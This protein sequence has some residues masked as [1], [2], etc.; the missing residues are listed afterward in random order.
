[1][2]LIKSLKDNAITKS[3]SGMFMKKLFAYIELSD[4][5]E[6]LEKNK[7]EKNK[8]EKN[9]YGAIYKLLKNIYNTTQH[10]FTLKD[11]YELNITGL[12]V[13]MFNLDTSIVMSFIL[14]A[15]GRK[16]IFSSNQINVPNSLVDL[17]MHVI[18][19]RATNEF[20]GFTTVMSMSKLFNSVGKILNKKPSAYNITK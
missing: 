2:G 7:L 19:D 17:R 20:V 12:V 9:K 5:L 15:I 3:E 8:L 10:K 4:A 14:R 16:K 18:T 11:L 13:P 6:K 1:M